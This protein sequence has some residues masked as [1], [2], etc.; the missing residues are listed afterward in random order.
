V[1]TANH[2]KMLKTQ[3]QRHTIANPGIMA[4]SWKLEVEINHMLSARAFRIQRSRTSS[5]VLTFQVN[6]GRGATVK[7]SASS[8]QANDA[9]TRPAKSSRRKSAVLTMQ[10]TKQ[11]YDPYQAGAGTIN[12][13]SYM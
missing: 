12:L 7:T 1:Q 4:A 11:P 10:D 3:H 5:V 13:T 8:L 2:A 6:Q 9:G